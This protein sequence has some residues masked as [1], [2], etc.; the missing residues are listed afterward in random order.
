MVGLF[1]MVKIQ[2]WNIVEG[3]LT[4][5]DFESDACFVWGGG[6][7]GVNSRCLVQVHVARKMRVSSPTPLPHPSWERRKTV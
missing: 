7:G 5:N 6:G 1:L 2:N 3:L 4:F